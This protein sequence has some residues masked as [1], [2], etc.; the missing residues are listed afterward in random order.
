MLKEFLLEKE[1]RTTLLKM[2]EKQIYRFG[3][4]YFM[5]IENK[6]YQ[7]FNTISR[8]NTC[9]LEFEEKFLKYEVERVTYN[10]Y[11]FYRITSDGKI[12]HLDIL[13]TEKPIDSYLFSIDEK[14]EYRNKI[15]LIEFFNLNNTDN[16]IY[17]IW[18]SRRENYKLLHQEVNLAYGREIEG[19]M[20]VIPNEK[21]AKIKLKHIGNS[22]YEI[23]LVVCDNEYELVG[24]NYFGSTCFSGEELLRALE[25]SEVGDEIK[26][27]VTNNIHSVN[28]NNFQNGQIVGIVSSTLRDNEYKVLGY[29]K[30]SLHITKNNL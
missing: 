11:D 14:D 29:R 6:I 4:F 1:E 28:I 8:K 5:R 23:Q 19:Y 2:E 3:D 20:V 25:N 24:L 18:N 21:F 27:N 13:E 17:E 30:G 10:T 16:E 7:C 12:G 9:I 15:R 22:I 26:F